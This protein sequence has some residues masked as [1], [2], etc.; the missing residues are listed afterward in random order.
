MNTEQ[1]QEQGIIPY[2]TIPIFNS[3]I[4]FFPLRVQLIYTASSVKQ[5]PNPPILHQEFFY[6]LLKIPLCSL[7]LPFCLP[8]NCVLE[9][10]VQT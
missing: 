5:T 1:D 8:Q 10:T 7:V 9:M 4:F 2:S 6:A 3:W